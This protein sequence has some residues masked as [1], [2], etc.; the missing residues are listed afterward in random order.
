VL[1]SF[2]ILLAVACSSGDKSE[3]RDA[4]IDSSAIVTIDASP[5]RYEVHVI[6]EIPG[7]SCNTPQEPAVKRDGATFRVSVQNLFSGAGVCTAD[8]GYR[9]LTIPLPGPF[10]PG[11]RYEVLINDEP[12]LTFVAE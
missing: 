12:A 3:L 6:A 10:Q 4:P 11:T 5:P 8:L 9:D 7:S 2:A 1:L